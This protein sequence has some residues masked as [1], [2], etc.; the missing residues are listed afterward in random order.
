MPIQN[1][2]R[3]RYNSFQEFMSFSKSKDNAPSF[4]NLFSVKFATPR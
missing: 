4:S 3:A 2:E 1:P